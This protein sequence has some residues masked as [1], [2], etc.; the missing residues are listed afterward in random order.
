M[1][2]E[3]LTANVTKQRTTVVVQAFT[4]RT[5]S[6]QLNSCSKALGSALSLTYYLTLLCRKKAGSAEAWLFTI[7][8]NHTTRKNVAPR[9]PCSQTVIKERRQQ[10]TFR[11]GNL[12]STS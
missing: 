8:S 4:I 6:Q 2:N 11:P 1:N 5:L 10:R 9:G 12:A 7:F 3:A